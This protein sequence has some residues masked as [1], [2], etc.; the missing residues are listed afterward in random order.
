MADEQ[1][2]ATVTVTG[3]DNTGP[4]AASVAANF[5]Q[6]ATSAATINQSMGTPLQQI[7]YHLEAI[8]QIS[9]EKIARGVT[10]A[11][12]KA[13]KAA[14][15]F[16]KGVAGGL[17]V[18]GGIGLEK[19]GEKIVEFSI[20]SVKKFA[21]A[22]RAMTSLKLATGATGHDIHA[23]EQTFKDLS[24][25]TSQ[26][27]ETLAT[28]FQ[29]LKTVSGFSLKDATELFPQIA[30][31][32]TLTTTSI[33]DVAKTAAYMGT[34]MKMSN[35]QINDML[36]GMV[37]HLKNTGG[38]FTNMF[39]AAAQPMAN[40]GLVGDKATASYMALFHVLQQAGKEKGLNEILKDAADPGKRTHSWVYNEMENIRKAGTGAIGIFDVIMK[41]M[42]SMANKKVM[43]DD[44][45]GNLILKSMGFNDDTIAAIR[46]FQ[47][48]Q[49]KVKQA[50]DGI[51]HSAGSAN[52]EMAERAK[53]LA[54]RFA[55]ISRAV[56]DL[57]ETMGRSLPGQGFLNGV[58]DSLVVIENSI[59]VVNQLYLQTKEL[60]GGKLSEKEKEIYRD[61]LK[62]L[63]TL[64]DRKETEKRQEQEG[65]DFQN[66]SIP[67]TWGEFFFGIDKTKPHW[68]DDHKPSMGGDGHGGDGHG[69]GHDKHSSLGETDATKQNTSAIY[70]LTDL[71]QRSE[72][73]GGFMNASFGRGG[74]AGG[75]GGGRGSG[76]WGSAEYPQIND[77]AG[78]SGG[79][80]G[81][82]NAGRSPMGGGA[83]AGPIPDIGNLG[84]GEMPTKAHIPN[85]IRMRNA[86]KEHFPELDD[87]H[88]NALLGE[89]S[90]ESAMLRQS[91]PGEQ[92]SGLIHFREGRRAGLQRYGN[93]MDPNANAK[94]IRDEMMKGSN[95]S[96][97]QRQ[98]ARDFLAAKTPGEM[99]AALRRYIQYGT[100]TT[101]NRMQSARQWSNYFKAY[102]NHKSNSDVPKGL[103]RDMQ[104]QEGVPY[105]GGQ[106][107]SST[108]EN[109]FGKFGGEEMQQYERMRQ[110]M[111]RPIR[112]NL[113]APNS[114][115]Q[116][117]PYR[118]RVA[119]Q[120][121]RWHSEDQLSF[122]R[123][124][125]ASDIGIA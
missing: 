69:G 109:R 59:K 49:D 111:E 95:I 113:I 57:Y 45:E 53:D 13:S 26:S 72:M 3:I 18:A 14:E 81:G 84:R 118:Q 92:A 2:N 85:A 52:K 80:G 77:P 93:D 56:D 112:M 62:A 17:G 21:E 33:D 73:K 106:K 120:Q 1:T 108:V 100:N 11:F 116:L 48:E 79:S 5:K 78:G 28:A 19:I 12:Q 30:K 36:D 90:N 71:L 9:E 88:I 63:G 96:P 15:E 87:A 114:P 55:E 50:Y 119:R 46:G 41:Q 102:D 22:E 51:R 105:L 117:A 75:G 39:T 99:H 104:P 121:N 20:E 110:Q 37:T 47:R 74:G 25:E 43:Q 6:I 4:M 122:H 68:Q 94:Y 42:E 67:K 60:F 61:P 34:Q 54:A 70:K 38:A 103:S 32:A 16:S 23:L 76:A 89:G 44:E 31:T 7:K 82:S 83:G 101:G 27:V 123:N 107:D 65:K 35:G 86:F 97:R 10:G 58:R 91:N 98:G 8:G 124:S 115:P 64:G 66:K 125:V 40:L 24:V 29:K